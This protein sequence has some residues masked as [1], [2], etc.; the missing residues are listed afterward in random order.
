M[1]FI[2]N[3]LLFA[4]FCSTP[5]ALCAAAATDSDSANTLLT[6][7][8][9]LLY[10]G[11][12][13]NRSYME[14]AIAYSDALVWYESQNDSSTA[15]QLQAAIYWCRHKASDDSIA[16][17]QAENLLDPSKLESL[18]RVNTLFNTPVSVD[19]AKEY[20]D[21]AGSFAENNPKSYYM[22]AMLYFEVSER[23]FA[24]QQGRDAKER[25][26]HLLR[27]YNKNL[28][29]ERISKD[30]LVVI[31]TNTVTTEATKAAS[32]RAPVPSETA[33]KNGI[34]AIHDIYKSDYAT[35]KSR[36]ELVA[37]LVKEANKS[38][39]DP[40][41]VYALL[42]E[43]RELAINAKNVLQVLEITDQLASLYEVV[44]LKAEKKQ[45]LL[46]IRGQFIVN[47]LIRLLDEPDEAGANFSVGMWYAKEHEE[48]H[49]ALPYL[50]KGTDVA[51]A[52]AAKSELAPKTLAAD[53]IAT[54]DMWYDL[55]KRSSSIKE[56]FWRHALSLYETARPQI[57]GLPA[58][59]L[60]KRITELV[61]YLPIGPNTD[62]DKLTVTQWEKLNGKTYSV[63]AA[64]DR[65][66][67]GLKLR[68]GQK[69]RVVPHPA[70]TWNITDGRDLVI[71][72]TYK[73]RSM[74]KNGSIGELLCSVGSG[75]EQQI[76]IVSGIGEITLFPSLPRGK[77]ARASGAIR[78]KIIPV[79]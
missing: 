8:N 59:V 57:T 40:A 31:T 27:N 48:W 45:A 44:D 6:S 25:M 66:N 2:A 17:I 77:K 78:V 36:A 51:Y 62:Y 26:D 13:N 23:F 69:V 1:R 5:A 55:G 56:S 39:N 4:A 24:Q 34:D 35:S 65:L 63:N 67:T 19:K 70:D 30:D 71:N 9:P 68:D 46:K 18:N 50:A 38:E 43:A 20:F 60:D 21:F 29:K 73:G 42:Y 72:T 10:D 14:A 7:A 53:I 52:E 12:N 79:N 75:E 15:R 61:A 54:A 47:S 16:A 58:A 3:L 28:R 76:G 64:N 37:K 33:L 41:S 32:V 22:S 74:R 49:S 11:E